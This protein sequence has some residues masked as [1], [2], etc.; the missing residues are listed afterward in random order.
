MKPTNAHGSLIV[1]TGE[2]RGAAGVVI[3]ALLV[4]ACSGKAPRP[5]TTEITRKP[6]HG[7][8]FCQM[9][10]S[11]RGWQCVQDPKLA[12]NPAPERLPPA[13][14]S[15]PATPA[16]ESGKPTI[17][18]ADPGAGE[19]PPSPAPKQGDPTPA[20]TTAQETAPAPPTLPAADDGV[21]AQGSVPDYVRLAYKPEQSLAIADMPRDYY[22]LQVLAMPTRR[23]LDA[24][25]TRHGI[26]GASAARVERDG[27]LYYVLLLGIYENS[28]LARQAATN[29]PPPFTEV[30]AWV[31]PVGSLQAAMARADALASRNA[32]G[33]QP[34]NLAR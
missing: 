20:A 24:F 32:S 8:W 2:L 19:A 22:A 1:R 10:E 9:D 7:D 29:L 21:D 25:V 23:A 26:S 5:S 30:E 11:G 13:A 14:P 3:V 15:S 17:P 18:Q 12:T 34:R 27:A 16:T 33:S 6:D 31:R 4:A 28:D